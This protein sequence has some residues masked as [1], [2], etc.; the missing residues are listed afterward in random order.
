VQISLLSTAGTRFVRTKRVWF[1]TQSEYGDEISTV[2]QI[3][4]VKKSSTRQAKE[5]GLDCNTISIWPIALRAR[6]SPVRNVGPG[7]WL[8]SELKLE[9]PRS[10]KAVPCRSVVRNSNLRLARPGFLRCLC[11]FSSVATFIGLNCAEARAGVPSSREF[12]LQAVR[13]SAVTHSGFAGRS[14]WSTDLRW[15]LMLSF[16][17]SRSSIPL[18]K[19]TAA[20]APFRRGRHRR[21]CAPDSAPPA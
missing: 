3:A 17:L 14:C 6:A 9:R 13:G 5:S 11:L 19:S 8:G 16:S 15:G 18:V 10:E 1:T 21:T 7:L 12:D 4:T 2:K 20:P